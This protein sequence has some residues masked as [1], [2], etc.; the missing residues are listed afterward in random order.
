MRKSSSVCW[1]SASQSTRLFPRFA[2]CCCRYLL[3]PC[4]VLLFCEKRFSRCFLLS[5]F[6][7]FLFPT[8]V[9]MS[10]G[11]P[12]PSASSD[13]LRLEHAPDTA[14]PFV[15]QPVRKTQKVPISPRLSSHHSSFPSFC[16]PLTAFC[17]S[18][19]PQFLHASR[20]F[21]R[22]CPPPMSVCSTAA[23]PGRTCAVW[24][25]CPRPTPV[26]PRRRSPHPQPQHQPQPQPL[27]RRAGCAHAA[28]PT[29]GS[30]AAQHGRTAQPRSRTC[31]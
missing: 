25:S 31:S 6:L 24:R 16:A 28:T 21:C 13:L 27:K 4:C 3:Q 29:D 20:R 15:V 19:T 14:H 2:W 5:F 9:T 23:P 10:E 7:F 11:G 12:A 26:S 30:T 17:L 18:H 22:R 1:D 8:N